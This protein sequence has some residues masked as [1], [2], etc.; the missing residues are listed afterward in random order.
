VTFWLT[1]LYVALIGGA[2][3]GVFLGIDPDLCIP[4]GTAGL[5]IALGQDTYGWWRRG[6]S[7]GR[8]ETICGCLALL[9]GVPIYYFGD[10]TAVLLAGFGGFF[11]FIFLGFAAQIWGQ[12]RETRAL[13]KRW[14]S[15]TTLYREKMCAELDRYYEVQKARMLWL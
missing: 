15:Y 7:P 9:C 10:T 6:P 2:T 3:A 5:L 8:M 12:T 4:V 13:F 14:R 11:V 1:A